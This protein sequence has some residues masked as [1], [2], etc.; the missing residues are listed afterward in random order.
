MKACAA[1]AAF[2]HRSETESSLTLCWRG[3]SAA[4]PSLNGR[5]DEFLESIKRGVET[6]AKDSSHALPAFSCNQN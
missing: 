5:S 2:V 3:E 1:A 4:N 6:P